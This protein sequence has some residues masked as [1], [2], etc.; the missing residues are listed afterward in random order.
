MT[1][2][3]NRFLNTLL[4]ENVKLKE[5]SVVKFKNM[6]DFFFLSHTVTVFGFH[7]VASA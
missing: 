4:F 5:I 6:P 3:K 2:R 1:E 7:V